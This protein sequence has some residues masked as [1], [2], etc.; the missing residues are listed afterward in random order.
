MPRIPARRK[1]APVLTSV[2]LCGT[3]LFAGT[4]AASASPALPKAVSQTKL[5]T[6]WP[7][8]ITSLDPPNLSTTED[9]NLSRNIYQ[10]LLSPQF[11]TEGDG[12]LKFVGAHVKPELAKSWTIGAD[13][14]T[15]HLRT[16]VKFA[17]TNDVM[18][19]QDVKWSLDRIWAT[20]SAG[21]L[22]A[23]GLQKPSEIHV[24]DK[25]TITIDFVDSTGKPTPVTPTLLAIFD[26]FSTAIIDSK[27]VIPHETKSD[28]TAATWLRAHAAGTG[29]YYIASRLSGVSLVLQAV[30]N[31][32]NPQPS[33]KT[34]DIQI[35]T[36]SIASLLE[37]GQINMD[38]FVPTNQDVNTLGKAGFT[39]DWQNTGFFD[40]FAITAS[41]ASQVGP[42]ANVDVRQAM[43][44]AMPYSTILNNVIYGRGL[45]DLSIVSPS[46]PEYTP[47]W[48]MYTTNID[49]AKAL[50]KA[51]GNPSVHVPL[52][53]LSS[54]VDQTSTAILIQ[55]SLKDIGVT[56]TLT[57]VTQA[58][59]FDVVDARSTPATG[60]KLGP[61]G[62]ELFNWSAWTDD[63]KIVIGYWATKG[64]INNYSL[65][66]SP[67]VDKTNTT[68]ALK[69]T[70]A[71]RTAA[72]KQAQKIIAAAAPVIP[73]V[74]TGSVVVLAKGVSGANF[75]PGGS[76]RYWLFHPTGVTN[77]LDAL[78]K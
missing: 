12:S 33:Y 6:A 62:V 71:A 37:G 41:P 56:T 77:P 35:T 46:A 27:V 72:Y 9:H 17:G 70:S 40:M 63:P 5:I 51:A 66:S 75:A 55:A 20:P 68:F 16:G 25:N 60:A 3:C 21:D 14:L 42:L 29:P 69:P 26:Q 34:V 52:Y 53:Y 49:K 28:P 38:E 64:G 19:A 31:S 4:Q 65:W 8:D 2:A 30:P 43:A 74:S 32:W 57:P 13:S 1:V 73:I 61:P 23:N 67:I 59:L 44:Y 76:G 11:Q 36:S 54:D 45:R 15:F 7:A 39:V 22:E 50:M 47:A 10:T 58:G 24:V 78:F 48:S 18:T